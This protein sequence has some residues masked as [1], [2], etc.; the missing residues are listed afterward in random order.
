MPADHYTDPKPIDTATATVAERQAHTL[1]LL[2]DAERALYRVR[3]E[4]TFM[5]NILTGDVAQTLQTVQHAQNPHTAAGVGLHPGD[6]SWAERPT[7][8][9]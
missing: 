1:A 8:T 3:M 6:A 5:T 7:P 4:G 2:A 9:T